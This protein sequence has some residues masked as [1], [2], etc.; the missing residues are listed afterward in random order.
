MHDAPEYV[1]VTMYEDELSTATR[2]SI[3]REEYL[4]QSDVAN[5]RCK[6]KLRKVNSVKP[7]DPEESEPEL[8]DNKYDESTEQD[9]E[10]S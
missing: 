3:E 5:E 7:V 2:S 4:L 1:T 9:H 8:E 10:D 6:R